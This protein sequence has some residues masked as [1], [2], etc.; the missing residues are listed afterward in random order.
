M[1]LFSWTRTPGKLRRPAWIPCLSYPCP[2]RTACKT[3][4]RRRISSRRPWPSILRRRCRPRVTDKASL[5][6]PLP[7]I[8]R[9]RHRQLARVFRFSRPSRLRLG[10]RMRRRFPHYRSRQNTYPRPSRPPP[11][12]SRPCPAQ[13]RVPQAGRQARLPLTP[14]TACSRDRIPVGGSA[15]ASRAQSGERVTAAC[16]A[17]RSASRLRSALR[18]PRRRRSSRAGCHR[19]RERRRERGRPKLTSVRL[20]LVEQQPQGISHSPPR[21]T[22]TKSCLTHCKRSLQ[23]STH[24]TPRPF[25]QICNL[26]GRGSLLR[27]DPPVVLHGVACDM[28]KLPRYAK[29]LRELQGSHGSR[30]LTPS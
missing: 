23:V 26:A 14:T 30:L 29:L 3:F 8:C 24:Y 4:L 15:R 10:R 11:P 7:P 16:A 20:G 22:G 12:L 17:I 9:A 6:A 21:H 5:S 27:L 1:S 18:A 2:R 28:Q 19:R 25:F 13:Q